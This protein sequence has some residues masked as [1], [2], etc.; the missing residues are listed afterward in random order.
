[1]P[2]NQAT[3]L[4]QALKLLSI[5]LPCRIGQSRKVYTSGGRG[6]AVN[7]IC[8]WR[9]SIGLDQVEC[10]ICHRHMVQMGLGCVAG[11]EWHF[12]LGLLLNKYIVRRDCVRHAKD[13]GEIWQGLRQGNGARLGEFGPWLRFD[14]W[15]HSESLRRPV[16]AGTEVRSIW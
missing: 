6:S 10:I 12:W 7:C 2:R 14:L 16:Q 11:C 13:T 15:E 1:M 8:R 5:L 9:T 3:I 4:T